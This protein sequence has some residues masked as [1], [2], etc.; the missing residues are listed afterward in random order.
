MLYRIRHRTELTYTAPIAESVMEV[1]VTPR[2]SVSQTL[3]GFGVAVGPA[4]RITEHVDWL[5]NRVHQFSILDR[6]DQIVVL[7]ES[8]VETHPDHPAFDALDARTGDVANT[9]PRL[10]D[11]IEFQGPI[12]RDSRLADLAKRL[13]LTEADGLGATLDKITKNLKNEL[14]YEKGVTE[15]HA[16]VSTVLGAGRGV[17]QDFA[18]VAIALL[19]ARGIPARYV[20][21]Y[22][23]RRTGPAE[24][25]THAWLEAH[26]SREGWVP[27]D[28]THGTPV[29]EEHMAVAIGRH[30]ADVPANRGVYRGEAKES[31]RVA[32]TIE[33]IQEVPGGLLVP[34]PIAPNLPIAE[35]DVAVHREAIEYDDQQQ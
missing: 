27:L 20:A 26:A 18:H 29:H 9:D 28:P 11:F 4:A 33:A 30:S 25:E 8:A 23:H 21:G 1:R 3:R 22:V 10:Y 13:G 15:S 31:I 7:S 35:E 34:E 17:C 16:G 5:G 14:V 32:V 6:H 19:R 2:T 24:L 12:E